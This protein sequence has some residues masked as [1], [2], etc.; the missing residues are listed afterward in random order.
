MPPSP[1]M[2]QSPDWNKFDCVTVDS[3]ACH[4]FGVNSKFTEFRDAQTIADFVLCESERAGI[5][6]C[7]LDSLWLK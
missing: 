7:P 5:D 4:V 2:N 6:V 1:N 3:H